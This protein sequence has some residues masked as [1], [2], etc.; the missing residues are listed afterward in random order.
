MSKVAVGIVLTLLLAV[1]AAAAPRNDYVLVFDERLGPY[2]YLEALQ[3]GKS[4]PAAVDAF[5][6]PSSRGTTFQSNLCTARWLDLGLEIG[7]AS[8]FG[9]C[10]RTRLA[11]SVWHGMTLYSRRWRNETGLRIGD[12]AL[13]LRRLY[14]R[15]R[16]VDRP[17]GPPAY[18]LQ[19]GVS[20][21]D[22]RTP[23]PLL[24][25]EI[26]AGRVVSITVHAGY[27]F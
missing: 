7:F 4:Y 15:A 19:Q 25:A 9:P 22:E 13:R 16:F 23:V 5:G 26:W 3:E 14:P 17:L 10:A 8:G 20:E 1:T 27:I 12:T 2:R 18:W 21:A 6:P 11:R 24:T